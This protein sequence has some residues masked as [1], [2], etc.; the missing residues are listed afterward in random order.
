MVRKFYRYR[1]LICGI[2]LVGLIICPVRTSLIRV[3]LI[4]LS[5]TLWIR[6]LILARKHAVVRNALI[7]VSIAAGL[8]FSFPIHRPIDARSLRRTYVNELQRYNQVHYVYGGENFCGI[9]CSGLVR[10]AMINSLFK[11]GVAS[12]NPVML[13]SA[14]SLWWHD[15]NAV[16]LGNGARGFTLLLGNGDPITLRRAHDL[17]PGD[18]AVTTS[19]SHV[20][21][22]LGG[23]QW[24]EADPGVARVHVVELAT[25][26]IAGEEVRIVRW[27]WLN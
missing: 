15:A 9:D 7:V 18:L 6:L 24:I 8:F 19:G 16:Q 23:D 21:A 14:V 10:A 25:S 20:L 12:L 1:W 11:D 26:P 22:Y 13:R 27:R 5:F 3:A 2:A 4:F 17:L